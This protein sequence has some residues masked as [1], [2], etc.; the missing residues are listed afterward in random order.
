MAETIVRRRQNK[1][2]QHSLGLT[3]T[4]QWRTIASLATL[5]VGEERSWCLRDR[6]NA[7]LCA[8]ING[9]IGQ[10]E[11]KWLTNQ[12]M[13][14]NVHL[15]GVSRGILFSAGVCWGILEYTGVRWV[16]SHN[17]YPSDSDY[18]KFDICPW[19]MLTECLTKFWICLNI[20]PQNVVLWSRTSTIAQWTW[21]G[22]RAKVKRTLVCRYHL[23]I[24]QFKERCVGMS[25]LQ[26]I[27]SH[28]NFSTSGTQTATGME[29]TFIFNKYQIKDSWKTIIKNHYNSNMETTLVDIIHSDPT[30]RSNTW[31]PLTLHSKG[32]PRR[33]SLPLYMQTKLSL[34]FYLKWVMVADKWNSK[35]INIVW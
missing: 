28:S 24:S 18:M 1:G 21:S 15:L 23:V 33:Q 34:K 19:Y 26:G 30:T 35:W 29:N 6:R 8:E 25:S 9:R 10:R 14:V 11:P 5:H 3:S 16:K 13:K 2:R 4:I 20:C 31:P 17:T 7:T 22:R 27:R 12:G 32:S